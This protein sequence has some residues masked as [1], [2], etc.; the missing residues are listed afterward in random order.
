MDLDAA[1]PAAG[2]AQPAAHAAAG[3]ALGQAAAEVRRAAARPLAQPDASLLTRPAH[4]MAHLATPAPCLSQLYGRLPGR[5]RSIRRLAASSQ[6]TPLTPPSHYPPAQATPQPLQQPQQEEGAPGNEGHAQK[7]LAPPQLSEPRD[8][9]QH[10][11]ADSLQPTN[12]AGRGSG[13]SRRSD[14]GN[15]AAFSPQVGGGAPAVAA[16]AEHGA[17]ASDV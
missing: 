1:A 13:R 4:A 2:G 15:P 5:P 9:R 14:S 3:A 11:A 10:A 8:P 16:W 12:Q 17:A 7:N 6:P